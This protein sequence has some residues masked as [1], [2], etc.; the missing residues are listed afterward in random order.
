MRKT[1]ASP[2]TPKCGSRMIRT[3]E[4]DRELAAAA[5]L[6]TLG[7]LRAPPPAHDLS[8]RSTPARISLAR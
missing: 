1:G 2:S 4:A 8:D 3:A 5:V 6:R 7:S